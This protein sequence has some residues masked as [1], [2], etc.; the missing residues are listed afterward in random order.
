MGEYRPKKVNIEWEW[1]ENVPAWVWAVVVI[2]G[3]ILLGQCSA[4]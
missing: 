4:G 3:L 2:G 1:V